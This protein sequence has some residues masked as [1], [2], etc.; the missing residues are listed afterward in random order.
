VCVCTRAYSRN[1]VGLE[2]FDDK[3]ST[4][5]RPTVMAFGTLVDPTEGLFAAVSERVKAIMDAQALACL[6]QGHCVKGRTV[7]GNVGAGG[8]TISA[9]AGAGAG[10]GG[11]AAPGRLVTA[12]AFLAGH[13]EVTVAEAHAVRRLPPLSIKSLVHEPPQCARFAG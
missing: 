5:E 3:L 4:S 7:I 1:P 2:V 11:D 13:G 9:G 6:P 12:G 10:A 8:V